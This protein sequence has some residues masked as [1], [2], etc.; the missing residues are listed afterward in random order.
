[1]QKGIVKILP[2]R[3]LQSFLLCRNYAVKTF[4]HKTHVEKRNQKREAYGP[5]TNPKDVSVGKIGGSKEITE[6]VQYPIHERVALTGR[7]DDNTKQYKHIK[8][9]VPEF[10]VPDL[11]D[12]KLKAYVPWG[13]EDVNQTEFTPQ[14][15]FFATYA[16]DIKKDFTENRLEPENS[17]KGN[18]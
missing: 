10:V 13:I 9:M 12:F 15:L 7:F 4:K 6:K 14:D 17:E 3:Q 1:M 11:K 2:V 8:E 16:K 18:S 5:V